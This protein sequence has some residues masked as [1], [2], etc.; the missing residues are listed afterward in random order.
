M[1]YQPPRDVLR[2]F[3]SRPEMT[4][5]SPRDDLSTAQRCLEM[6]YQP[7]GDDLPAALDNNQKWNVKLLDRLSAQNNKFFCMIFTNNF[8]KCNAI[9]LVLRY[10]YGVW[11]IKLGFVFY[12]TRCSSSSSSMSIATHSPNLMMISFIV[13]EFWAKV[14]FKVAL[15]MSVILNSI[16][17]KL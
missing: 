15:C 6:T 16:V 8:Y 13:S 7:P 17:S 9:L 12:C 1:T 11:D 4:Y 10:T 2:W 5:Q 14:C 3:I